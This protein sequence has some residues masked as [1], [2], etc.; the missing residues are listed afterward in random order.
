MRG[1]TAAEPGEVSLLGWLSYINKGTYK[2][3][4]GELMP[5]TLDVLANTEGGAQEFKVEGS[6]WGIS[7]QLHLQQLKDNVVFNAAVSAITQG[8]G[9]CFL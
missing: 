5:G 3:S 1:I 4:K 9:M 2:N 6:A 7:N 8:P